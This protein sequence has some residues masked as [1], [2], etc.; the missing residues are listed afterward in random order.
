MIKL[1]LGT[2]VLMNLG[3]LPERDSLDQEISLQYNLR[4]S[5]K[6]FEDYE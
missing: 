2:G 4:W 3:I 1:L 6:A 5:R